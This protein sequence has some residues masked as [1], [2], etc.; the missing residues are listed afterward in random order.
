[1]ILK[2]N[3]HKN[4]VVITYPSILLPASVNEAICVEEV[5]PICG[6][7]VFPVLRFI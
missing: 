2:K 4:F 7:Q 6:F 5:K 3:M 1:M